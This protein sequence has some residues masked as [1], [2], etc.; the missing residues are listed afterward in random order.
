MPYPNEH[1][2]R[3]EEPTKFQKGSFRRLVRGKAHIIIGRPHGSKKTRAQ[4]IHYPAEKWTK[5]SAQQSCKKHGGKF[6]PA[7]LGVWDGGE[8]EKILDLLQKGK[9]HID[10]IA[11]K[12]EIPVHIISSK[13][14]MLELDD[15]VKRL[16]GDMFE[17]AAVPSA[18]RVEE[19]VPPPTP[20]R[21][22]LLPECYSCEPKKI[23]KGYK[24]LCRKTD[25]KC[26]LKP[27]TTEVLID[28]AGEEH[29]CELRQTPSGSFRVHCK[30]KKE[31]RAP[32]RDRSTT[33]KIIDKVR[34]CLRKEKN[35][36]GRTVCK[37]WTKNYKMVAPKDLVCYPPG[38]RP[39]AAVG[40][41]IGEQKTFLSED[42]VALYQTLLKVP[43]QWEASID[44]IAQATNIPLARAT[45]GL[46]ML[47]LKGLATQPKD[48][49]FQKRA[50]PLTDEQTGLIHNYA[51][52][53][54]EGGDFPAVYQ[55]LETADVKPSHQAL[56]NF[57][58][59][60][61]YPK[62]IQDRDYSNPNLPYQVKVFEKAAK[63]DPS[64]VISTAKTSVE[65]PPIIVGENNIVLS[66]NSRALSIIYASAKHPE[67][68]RNYV[69]Y[70]A[71][72]AVTF[73]LSPEAVHKMKQPM[74]VR[75]I[76]VP[77][78]TYKLFGSQANESPA[79]AL[80]LIGTLQSVAKY[81]PDEIVMTMDLG[82]EETL[83]AYIASSRGQRFAKAIMSALPATKVG[84]YV[85]RGM[86]TEEGKALI[87]GVLLFKLLP[88]MELIEHT[89]KILRNALSFSIPEFFRVKIGVHS[90]SMM[91][92][93]DITEY[94]PKAVEFFN[95]NLTEAPLSFWMKQQSLFEEED[96]DV[97]E[98]DT[99]W[100][101]LVILFD[102]Y[103]NSPRKFRDLLREYAGRA[104]QILVPEDPLEVLKE[105]IGGIG[106]TPLPPFGRGNGSQQSLFGGLLNQL[107]G[108]DIF[109]VIAE[110]M[111]PLNKGG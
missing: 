71:A 30:Q 23:K 110:G 15:K 96:K 66:G 94:L 29:T 86:L 39:P 55:I 27:G 80:D 49:I 64:R 109:D 59:S 10:D 84:A 22:R 25:V 38:Q 3:L 32:Q 7:R 102:K 70:L 87:E 44:E 24:F 13:L 76:A 58:W 40:P 51:H 53:S 90:G 33:E 78:S 14:L 36:Q 93:W 28:P 81:I 2:C 41:L 111:F 82:D 34:T 50:I 99:L 42:E 37:E 83:R 89:P 103:R 60:P 68:Y 104:E 43:R 91:E 56:N 31:T 105:L 79:M 26:D 45:Y 95:R 9:L 16:P 61:G 106:T 20:G 97:F 92:G 8:E 6:E 12:T 77:P 67:T 17:I 4:A 101:Q 62:E 47:E 1:S 11:I 46:T 21:T 19:T 48:K 5:K 54:G 98:E 57:R 65:G 107:M 35:K 72:H 52:P 108:L 85:D 63:L 75:R 74:L 18:R 88:N 73:G 69:D 100:G